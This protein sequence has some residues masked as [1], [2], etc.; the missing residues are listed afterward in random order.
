MAFLRIMCRYSH[1]PLPKLT[2]TNTFLYST[3]RWCFYLNLPI[4]GFTLLAVFLFFN[5]ESSSGQKAQGII[6][7]VKQLD[8]LGVLLF[9]PCMVCLILALQW[10]GSTYPWSAPTII[11]LLVTFAVLFLIFIFVEVMTPKTAM[12]PTR[13]ILNRS[14]AACMLYMLLLSGAMMSI[15]Y[16]LTIWFQTAKGDSPTDA[17]V[18]TIP[19]VLSM[20]V[21]IILLA[22]I[23]ERIGY[24]VPAML[25]SPVLCSVGAGLLSTLQSDSGHS[26]WI[27]YQVLYGFGIG[28][29]FQVSTLAAQTVLPRADVPI[30]LAMMFFMQQLGGSVFLAVSQNIFATQL[31]ARLSGVGGLDTEAILHAGA[32]ELHEVVPSDQLN[33]VVDAYSHSLTRV[34]LMAALLSACMTVGSLTVEWKSIKGETVATKSKPDDMETEKGEA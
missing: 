6:D 33:S 8:P 31:I 10:G 15:I 9:V 24:Y 22:K 2:S 27:G 7:Q 26:K 17:G 11:G 25:L 28:C 4:G 16:Y 23:T 21:M 5:F 12:A 19:I 14:I 29:G 3:W 34:F 13:V 1:N 20:V 30:G 32:T 18:K